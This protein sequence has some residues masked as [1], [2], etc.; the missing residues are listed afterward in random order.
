MVPSNVHNINRVSGMNHGRVG[1]CPKFFQYPLMIYSSTKI[2]PLIPAAAVLNG[3]KKIGRQKNR[4]MVFCKSGF[5]SIASARFIFNYR[6]H[7]GSSTF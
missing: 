6:P 1:I 4:N 5:I 2:P 3:K 7:H